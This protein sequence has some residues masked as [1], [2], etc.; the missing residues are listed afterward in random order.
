MRQGDPISPKLFTATIQEVFI[1]AQLEEKG[2]NTDGEKLSNLRFADDVAPT[3]ED[4]EDMEH[5]LNTVNEE[6]L[7]TG[8]KIYKGKTKF[9]TNIDT[10]DNIHMNRTEIGKVTNYK[11]EGRTIAMESG[12]KQEVSIRIKVGWSVLGTYREIFLDRHLPMSLK[13][14]VFDQCV[15]PAMTYEWQ[16]WSLTKALVKKLEKSQQAKERRML[17][18][19]LEDRIRNIISRPRTRVTD[20]VQYVTNTKL[21]WAGH[22]TQMKDIRWT[23]RSTEWQ[24]KGVRSVRRPKHHWRDDTVGQQGAAWTRIAKDR[25]RW[26]TVAEGYFLHWKDTA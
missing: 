16:T 14:K 1:N 11:Y 7:K 20:T 9:M 26:R 17:N 3:T 6:S 23:I 2:I 25:E 15:L 5:Q 10:T 22:N 18:V 21:K 19:K 8:L 24:I 4:L 13:R 12:T